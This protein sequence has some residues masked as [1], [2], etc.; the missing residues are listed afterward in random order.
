MMPLLAAG[1]ENWVGLG[2]ALLLLV[3]LFVTLLVPER[4]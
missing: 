3:F 4:F 1:V 2:V